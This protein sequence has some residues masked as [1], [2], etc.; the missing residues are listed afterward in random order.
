MWTWLARQDP[1][2]DGWLGAPLPR[3]PTC[4]AP[5]RG[6][7]ARLQRDPVVGPARQPD[8]GV[9]PRH[10]S[11]RTITGDRARTEVA[12]AAMIAYPGVPMIW[13]GDEVGL[14]GRHR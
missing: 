14:A 1:V 11:P 12:V 13:S 10:A 5:R 8:H 4:P 9:E 2:F 3:G 6:H 7:D